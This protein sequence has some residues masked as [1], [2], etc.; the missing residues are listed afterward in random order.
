MIYPVFLCVLCVRHAK[1]LWWGDN[2]LQMHDVDQCTAINLRVIATVAARHK[3]SEYKQILLYWIIMVLYYFILVGKSFSLTGCW[4]TF[5]IV[6]VSRLNFTSLQEMYD[7]G[8][9]PAVAVLTK[10]IIKPK[11]ILF[12]A[13][14]SPSEAKSSFMVLMKDSNVVNT[15]C[16]QWWWVPP[17]RHYCHIL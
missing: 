13:Q 8:Y 15:D 6:E 16:H 11:L 1:W 4:A 5:F 7:M 14:I 17:I 12:I 2:A 9:S 10:M 3:S